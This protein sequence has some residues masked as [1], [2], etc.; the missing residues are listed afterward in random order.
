MGWYIWGITIASKENK[1]SITDLV[2]VTIQLRKNNEDT[3]GVERQI[4]KMVYQIY[5]LTED[6]IKIVEDS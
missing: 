1:N 3:S 5:G 4:D 6:E 2:N